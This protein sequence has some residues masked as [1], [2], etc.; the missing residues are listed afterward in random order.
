ME[1]LKGYKTVGFFVLAALVYIANYF[2]FGGFELT[3][4]MRDLLDAILVVG[5]F[6]L[7]LATNSKA[8]SK[9]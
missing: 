8:F 7:R 6:A 5:G 1:K 9:E 2:G 4:E 3:P